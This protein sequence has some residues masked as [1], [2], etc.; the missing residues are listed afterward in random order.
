LIEAVIFDL[1][2]TLIELPMD[3]E[4]L[5]KEVKRILETEKA[6]PLSIT[7]AKASTRQRKEIFKIWDEIEL[8]A[9]SKVTRVDEG[10][11]TYLEYSSKPKALVT[12]QGKAMTQAILQQF[13]LS[14]KSIITREHSLDRTKQLEIAMQK[15]EVPNHNILFVGNENHDEQAAERMGCRFRRV[16]ERKSG[17]TLSQV[18]T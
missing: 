16:G 14:F 1:D 9:L 3:Y 5:F 4:W 12:M 15:L 10:T 7:V 8:A 18:N 13:S 6:R 11:E 17:M 2:G